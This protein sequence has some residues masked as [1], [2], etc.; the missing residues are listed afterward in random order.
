[1]LATTEENARLVLKIKKLKSKNEEL[2]FVVVAIENLKH[3]NEYRE[4]KFKVDKEVED[5]LVA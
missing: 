5:A 2:K 1:M 3:L 4:N